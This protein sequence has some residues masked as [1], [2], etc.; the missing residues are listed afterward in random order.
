[1]HKYLE[2]KGGIEKPSKVGK[3]LTG[4]MSEGSNKFDALSDKTANIYHRSTQILKK[5][6]QRMK[7]FAGFGSTQE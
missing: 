6:R 3:M 7:S 5:G 1:M 2:S 4:I